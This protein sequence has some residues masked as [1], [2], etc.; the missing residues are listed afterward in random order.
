[1]D[2]FPMTTMPA[3]TAELLME[4]GTSRRTPDG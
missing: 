2:H 1:M 4:V 3:E